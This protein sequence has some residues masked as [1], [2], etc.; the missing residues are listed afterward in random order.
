LP[1][2]LRLALLLL[3][4]MVLLLTGA[5]FNRPFCNCSGYPDLKI[6]L[7]APTGPVVLELQEKLAQLGY[8]EDEFDGVYGRKTAQA[9]AK[10]QREVGIPVTGNMDRATW[11]YLAWMEEGEKSVAVNQLP[12]PEGEISLLVDID[13]LIL[14]IYADGE[15]YKIYPVAIGKWTTPTPI[16]EWLVVNKIAVWSGPFGARWMGLSCPWGSYGIH[17]TDNPGSIGWEASSGCIRM[18]NQDVIE[19]YDWVP[20]NTPVKIIGSRIR[21]VSLPSRLVRGDV[22]QSVVPL[23]WK[24]QE[25]GYAIGRADGVYGEATEKAVR[26]LQYFYQLHPNGEADTSLLYLLGLRQEKGV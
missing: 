3:L 2:R 17:G 15:P 24:L 19:L 7:P 20:E 21:D 25:L 5:D 11:A 1:I 22:A 6:D 8:Y 23:Q 14:I 12:P 13:A 4:P 18:Y 10:L 9:V 16:G 26:E